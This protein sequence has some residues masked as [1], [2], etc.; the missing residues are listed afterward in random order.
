[1]SNTIRRHC[2][3][4][5]EVSH[6]LARG[7][8]RTSQTS[9]MFEATSRIEN[10][11]SKTISVRF[12]LLQG[13]KKS[14]RSMK[15]HRPT[16]LY[17]KCFWKHSSTVSKLNKASNCIQRRIEIQVDSLRLQVDISNR[18]LQLQIPQ[19]DYSSLPIVQFHHERIIFFPSNAVWL[20]PGRSTC[21]QSCCM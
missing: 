8:Q 16:Q 21:V 10:G 11:G 7:S 20:S 3:H 17:S 19:S 4:N 2:P 15:L 13:V 9:Q 14:L 5:A 1:M 12:T 18:L 6:I